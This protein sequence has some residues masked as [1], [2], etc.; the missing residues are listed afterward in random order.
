MKQVFQNHT[1]I[2]KS[3]GLMAI[4]CL[5]LS[6][7]GKQSENRSQHAAGVGNLPA[8]AVVGLD[9]GNRAPEIALPSPEGNIIALS[10]LQGKMVLIDFWASW[11]MPCRLENPHLVKVYQQY[12]NARFSEGKGF[13]IYSVSLDKDFKAWREGIRADNLGWEHHVSDLRGWDAAPAALYQVTSIP[14][15]L[16]IDGK[17]T[18]VAKNL[19]GEALELALK[20][21]L[22]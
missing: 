7:S 20:Q 10:S 9:I 4:L 18:I 11:C 22:K 12:R 1:G 2:C 8:K 13:T 3:A 14:S 15:N 5:M 6:C 19:R 17:G 16:L 21:Y